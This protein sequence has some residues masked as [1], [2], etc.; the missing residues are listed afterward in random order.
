MTRS[1]AQLWTS[2][3]VPHG[4][5]NSYF[6]TRAFVGDKKAG[7]MELRLLGDKARDRW[8]HLSGHVV[9]SLLIVAGSAIVPLQVG[10][11]DT[12]CVVYSRYGGPAMLAI[13]PSADLREACDLPGIP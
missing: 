8:A 4:G 2:P 12:V 5:T 6:I 1:K 13:V 10:A 3:V 9:K 7:E 11:T